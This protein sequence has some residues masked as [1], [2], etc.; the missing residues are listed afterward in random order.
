MTCLLAQDKTYAGWRSLPNTHGI[1][2]CQV[3]GSS[4]SEMHGLCH[5]NSTCSMKSLGL[6]YLTKYEYNNSY[7]LNLLTKQH[8]N[9]LKYLVQTR[10]FLPQIIYMCGLST[11][12]KTWIWAS[13]SIFTYCSPW[14]LSQWAFFLK[15]PP[16]E[17][18]CWLLPVVRVI[19]GN[20]SLCHPCYDDTINVLGKVSTADIVSE[21]T[22]SVGYG[23]IRQSHLG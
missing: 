3:Q 19:H 15:V 8:T 1:Y 21:I 4:G 17:K 16:A 2:I 18:Q 14:K 6:S 9:Y 12:K 10:S 7:F 11:P 5:Q 22:S 23:Q 13:V 20:I